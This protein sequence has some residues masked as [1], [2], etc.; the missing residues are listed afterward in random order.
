[1]NITI[2][3]QGYRCFRLIFLSIILSVPC[4]LHSAPNQLIREIPAVWLSDIAIAAYDSHGPVIYY[5]PILTEQVGPWISEFIRAHEL[6][7]HHLGHLQRE[8]LQSTP[9]N[10][11]WLRREFEREADCEAAKVV[12]PY[13]VLSAVEFFIATQGPTRADPYHP[14]GYE[15]AATIRDC[16]GD[17]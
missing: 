9:L 13:A 5:N 7:H 16:G 14:T 12:S 17:R 10:R 4:Y 6:F 8:K 2:T 1:M 3:R 15:R 11:S